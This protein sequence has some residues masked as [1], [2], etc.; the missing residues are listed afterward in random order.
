M[1]GLGNQVKTAFFMALLT[2]IVIIAGNALGGSNGM[3]LAFV[4]AMVM[5]F[6]SYWFSDKI[7]LKMTHSVPLSEE[8]SPQLF[9]M[10]ERLAQNAGLPTPRLYLTQSPQPNAFATGRNPSHAVIAVTEGLL[11]MMSKEELEGV[12][13]HEMAHI[14]NRDILIGTL[15]AVM[16]GVIT[17]L[18]HW[19]QWALIFGGGSR[20]SDDGG[21]LAALPLIILGPLAAAL[22]Q[23]ALS[24]SR[25]FQAD[26]SGAEIAGNSQGLAQALLKLERAS[27]AIP[28]NVSPSAS[29]LFIVN[30]LKKKSLT[31][32]FST[33]PPVQ[34]R[35]ERL[36]HMERR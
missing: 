21:G 9:A 11:S 7:A 2:I 10:V 31:T 15:A 12:L 4:F 20:D 35:V 16:A 22:I 25:E 17:T 33:H 8:Q 19:A 24:R 5:N 28:M 29:H 32:L 34:E 30:P 27:S 3:M 18:A 6:G 26:A 36:N 14:K 13:A 1:S 23:M